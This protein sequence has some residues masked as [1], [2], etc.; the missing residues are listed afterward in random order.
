MADLPIL[1]LIQKAFA[2][3][4]CVLLLLFKASNKF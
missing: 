3:T 4:V 2:D 1:E